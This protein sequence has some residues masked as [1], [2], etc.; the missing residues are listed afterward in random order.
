MLNDILKSI[1]PTIEKKKLSFQVF[2][3]DLALTVYG[4]WRVV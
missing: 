1:M 3:L 4:V 2:K